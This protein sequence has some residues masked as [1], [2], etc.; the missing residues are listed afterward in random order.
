MREPL[1]VESAAEKNV[2]I[3][4]NPRHGFPTEAEAEAFGNSFGHLRARPALA[5][6]LVRE[7]GETLI[8]HAL[9]TAKGK[10]KAL[11]VVRRVVGRRP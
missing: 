9:P 2:L 4:S 10:R 7:V 5:N 11:R 1:R 3:G 8:A 6:E